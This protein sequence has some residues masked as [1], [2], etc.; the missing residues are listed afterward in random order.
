MKNKKVHFVG[1]GGI[2]ISALAYYYLSEG[3]EVTGSD[4][5]S[6]IITERLKKAGARISIGHNKKNLDEKTEKVFKSVAVPKSNPEIKK[7]EKLR[8]EV[9]TYP[10]EVG[11]LT[12]KYRTIAVSG[13][14]GKG[15]T[16]AFLSLALIK[17]GF[18]PTVIIG[19]NLKEFGNKN[20]RKGKSR[21]LILEADEYKKAFLNYQPEFVITTNIDREHLDC[22]KNLEEIKETFLSFWKKVPSNG[23]V[24]LNRK[25]KNIKSLTQRKDFQKIKAEV[26]FF[27]FKQKEVGK[28]KNKLKIPGRHNLENA[29][30]A[31]TLTQKLGIN[32]KTA[33]KGMAQY[34]GAWRRFERKKIKIKGKKIT[35]VSDYAHHPSEI[36]STLQ[37]AR[38]EFKNRKIWTV[39]QPHQYQRTHYLFE[40]FKDCFNKT[41]KVIL[42][43]I[44][45]VAGR[46]EKSIKK[47]VSGKKLMESLNLKKENKYFVKDFRK[48]KTFLKEKVEDGDVVVI[49]GAGDIYK[50]FDNLIK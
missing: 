34:K 28:F 11:E 9:L 45:D 47:K 21:W 44:Y 15:T 7:A 3:A 1:I 50:V 46:E 30:G 37:A 20:F 40:E 8:I 18:D 42:T 48:I 41:D 6:S 10:E 4:L 36:K 17:A 19:T 38:E 49:M 29:L 13:A 16:T 22:F 31:L 24:V 2:G 39:F 35:L 14:H 12:K 33:I 32:E 27:S 5:N 43:E 26:C 25:D 23:A